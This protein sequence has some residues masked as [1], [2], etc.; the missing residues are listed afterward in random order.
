MLEEK[1]VLGVTTVRER[2]S[3]S[4]RVNDIDTI[5]GVAQINCVAY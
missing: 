3:A 2:E 4:E 1:N 5:F